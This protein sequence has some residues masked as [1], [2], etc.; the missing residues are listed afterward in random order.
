MSQKLIKVLIVD[1][2]KSIIIFL[3]DMLLKSKRC[4]YIIEPVTSLK[5]ALTK[6]DS[7]NFDIILLDLNLTDSSNLDTLNAINSKKP[8]MPI[9]VI[10]G[11]YGDEIGPQVISHGAQ[12]YLVK[13]EFD[14]NILDKSIDFAIERKIS[15]LNMI[16]KEREFRMM[17]ENGSD[18]ITLID[19]KGMILY[20]SPSVKKQLGYE[21][22][23]LIGENILNF[24]HA[25]DRQR[26]KKSY[27]DLFEK[28]CTSFTIEYRF[29]TSSGSWRVLESH[30]NPEYSSDQSIPCAIINSRDI[31]QR[32]ETEEELRKHRD[33]LESLVR[34]RTFELM[35]AKEVAETANKAKSEFIANMSH[36]LRTPLNSIIGF[37]KLMKMGYNPETYEEQLDNILRSGLRLLELMNNILDLVKIDAGKIKFEKKPARLD[38]IINSCVKSIREKPAYKNKKIEYTNENLNSVI[39]GDESRLEQ[40]FMQILSNAVKFT[41]DNGAIKINNHQKNEFI[42]I[43]ITDNG[44]GIKEEVLKHIFDE[45]HMG[46]KGLIRDKQGA[47]IGL[48]IVKKIIEAHN[49]SISVK[50]KEGLGSTFTIL[51]PA[52]EKSKITEHLH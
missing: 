36:E 37:S 7:D 32:K 8:S 15:E 50:S 2:Q 27:G 12:D 52:F 6:L 11:A 39:I 19:S 1:D 26:I 41:D 43:N 4:D 29:R 49:G 34:E 20:E 9:I 23:D 51:M 44:T 13:G 17:I 24:I 33:N 14:A 18:I 45:F 40:M 5:L 30:F 46:E 38:T 42:E 31:T 22:I 10:T 47:G 3:S 28:T 16:N 25:E 48:S 35:Y 21:P